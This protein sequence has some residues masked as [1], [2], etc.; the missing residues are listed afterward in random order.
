[1]IDHDSSQQLVLIHLSDIHFG[2]GH[3]F[4]PPAS[5]AG[6][7]PD[8]EC[9]PSLISKLAEDLDATDADCPI[10]VCVTGDVAQTAALDEFK[11]SETFL[12]AMAEKPIGGRTL[13]MENIFV[14]PG[15]HDVKYD[16]AD[17]GTRWQ[18]W[19]EFYN[20]LYA[21]A[22]RREEP[23]EF[24][25]L[26]DRSDDLGAIILCLNSSIFVEKDKPDEARGRLD[27]KQLTA[28]EESL[29]AVSPK[30]L[31][32][33]IKVALIHH[34]PVLIPSLAEPGRGYDAVH[35]SGK[36]LTILRR[37]GFHAILHGHKHNP[38]TFTDD[39]RPAH[40]DLPEQPILI[41]AGGSVGCT[42]LPYSPKPLN[43]Y[44]QITIK[45]H[46]TGRQFRVRT[47]T[48]CL[49]TF[50][51]DGT[52]RLPTRWQW[53]TLRTDD[54]KFLGD[55]HIPFSKSC[56]ERVFDPAQDA[57]FETQRQ[58]VY[59]DTR[60]NMPVV[61]V[62][63]SLTPGQAYEA[64]LWIVQ[65]PFGEKK[66]E[67]DIPR[68]VTWSAGRKF[69]VVTVNGEQDS[70]YAARLSYYGPMLVQA[71]LSFPDGHEAVTHVY[72]RMPT[73]FTAPPDNGG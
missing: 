28:I 1:M 24:M 8:E 27:I 42:D 48:R 15:N 14:V 50:N 52:E 67:S 71:R 34:H 12:K 72:A 63:P 62:L 21:T 25:K 7:E 30:R 5:P 39:T 29:E 59:V 51:N 23:W 69:E 11:N 65:H 22:I 55:D 10:V 38:H 31:H 53:E 58:A 43:C 18:Q 26:H 68:T 37:Y 4:N 49:N 40:Q 44:N 70:N 17:V 3:R 61:D 16:S 41:A 33:A 66:Q 9:F 47:V 35:N 20:R 56:T 46:S 45:W 57:E 73:A 54:R 64:V 6:D 36:L 2:S 19:T 60:G 32:G 13:G